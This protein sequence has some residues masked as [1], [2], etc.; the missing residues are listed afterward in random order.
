MDKKEH[1][2]DN[3]SDG[4]DKALL[5]SDNEGKHIESMESD[6]TKGQPQLAEDSEL[7][8]MD[9]GEEEEEIT[10]IEISDTEIIDDSGKEY[11]EEDEEEV[12]E[13]FIDIDP[14]QLGIIVT[15]AELP[16]DLLGE[17]VNGVYR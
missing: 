13:G 9:S 11:E 4:Q 10:I 8:M 6:E 16:D 2:M 14:S 17:P 1:I 7:E 15:E 12:E 3:S 5:L